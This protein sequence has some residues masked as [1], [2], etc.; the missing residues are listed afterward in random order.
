[1]TGNFVYVNTNK[2]HNFARTTQIATA[3]AVMWKV[4]FTKCRAA[5]AMNF[6]EPT[7]SQ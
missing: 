1:M 6:Q 4:V 7:E 2:T 3:D 5:I